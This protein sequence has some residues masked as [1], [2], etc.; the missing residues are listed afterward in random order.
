[1]LEA[2]T[3]GPVQVNLSQ[4]STFL[5]SDM[6]RLLKAIT[7]F[8]LWCWRVVA[9]ESE[10]SIDMS[11]KVTSDLEEEKMGKDLAH[12]MEMVEALKCEL[13][14][15]TSQKETSDMEKE[16]IGEE[17]AHAV[18]KVE[19]LKS[20]L[21]RTTSQKETSDMERAEMGKE[22]AHAMEKV[23]VLKSELR[24]VTSQKETSDMEKEEMGKKLTHDMDKLEVLKSELRTVTS[25]KETSDKE[26]EEMGKDLAHAMEKLEVLKSELRTVTSQKETSDMEKEEMG[27]EL[28]HAMEKLEVLKSEMRTIISQKETSDMEKEEMGKELAHAMEKLEVLKSDL[29]TVTSQ[30]ETSDMEKEEMGKELAHAMEKLEVLQSELRTVTS[31]KENSDVETAEMGKELAQAVEKVEVLKSELKT[32]TSQKDTSDMEKEEMRKELAHAME[33]VEVL[34]SELRT[35]ISEKKTSDLEKAKIDGRLACAM[36]ELATKNRTRINMET[37]TTRD[38]RDLSNMVVHMDE[39]TSGVGKLCDLLEEKD[40]KN[41]LKRQ[42]EAYSDISQKDEVIEGL[43]MKLDVQNCTMD[44]RLED[45]AVIQKAKGKNSLLCV[46]STNLE[47][48][49]GDEWELQQCEQNSINEEKLMAGELREGVCSILY[50]I[51]RSSF[52]TSLTKILALPLT[53]TNI[54]DFACIIHDMA[55]NYPDLSEVIANLSDAMF[56]KLPDEIGTKMRNF[57]LER[58]NELLMCPN[59]DPA[60]RAI[61]KDLDRAQSSGEKEMLQGS[62]NEEQRQLEKCINNARF[63]G[64]LWKAGSIQTENIRMYIW[65]LLGDCDDL[66]MRCL[67][68]LLKTVAKRLEESNEDLSRYY[69]IIVEN[70]KLA[71]I[72]AQVKLDFQNLD[73][74]R[75]KKSNGQLN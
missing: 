18:E 29:R 19:A 60:T 59:V 4:A 51:R 30:K 58:C 64:E 7:S 66:S 45:A 53:I 33:E 72:S 32:A 74:V 40:I 56:R 11:R 9:P 71:H 36:K 15:A 55:T 2:A 10:T 61:I 5:S 65:K 69:N 13:R 12:A 20:E 48:T 44:A 14:T 57:L 16:E 75:Y 67:Y 3:K 47:Q 34:K 70:C 26:K 28:A 17:L 24:T 31:Q 50:Q 54:E 46:N 49:N 8:K 25:Q 6:L 41:D 63:T 43:E 21:K 38:M 1:V 68:S 35:A 22:L 42:E 23:E 73:E 62:Y 27:K 52:E 39:L 37:Q